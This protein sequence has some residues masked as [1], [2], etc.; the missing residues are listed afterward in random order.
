VKNTT[1]DKIWNSALKRAHRDGDIL[2]APELAKTYDCSTRTVRDAL[3]TMSDFG[4]L[5]VEATE[6][7][8]EFQA[9]D[10]AF[11]DDYVPE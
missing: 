5:K 9:D 11:S 7:A 3:H 6:Y 10:E 1:R 2:T 4:F 8:T